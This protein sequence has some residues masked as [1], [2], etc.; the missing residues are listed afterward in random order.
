VVTELQRIRHEHAEAVAR[1]QANVRGMGGEPSRESGAWGAFAN[2][3]QSTAN[4]FGP[5][6]AIESLQRGE[7]HGRNDYQDALDDGDVM[8]GCKAMI[9]NELLPRIHRHIATLERLEE[10]V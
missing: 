4:L 7:E 8:E 6:S 3:V 2:T 10:A 5:G 1:L 9:R